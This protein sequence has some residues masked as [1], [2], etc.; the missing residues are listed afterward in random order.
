M[1]SLWYSFLCLLYVLILKRDS[2]WG[3]NSVKSDDFVLQDF[4]LSSFVDNI[5]LTLKRLLAVL[6]VEEA[7]PSQPLSSGFLFREA[8]MDHSL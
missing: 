7:D 3:Q 4:I 2:Q 1:V 6:L 8:M 5:A